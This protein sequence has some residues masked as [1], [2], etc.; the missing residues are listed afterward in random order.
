MRG[1]NPKHVILSEYSEQDP[2][3][4]NKVI[5][6]I[7]D[8]NHWKAHFCFTPK[9]K[10]HSYQLYEYARNHPDER[11]VSVKKAY[12]L[13]DDAGNRIITDEEL[14][15]IKQYFIDMGDVETYYQ[16]YECSF[17]WST[18]WAYYWEQLRIAEEEWR[19]CTVPYE[20]NL[21][22]FSV[23][24]MGMDDSTAIRSFQIFWKELR[25]LEYFHN[26]GKWLDFYANYLKES[27]YKYTTHF[28]PH[29]AEVRELGTWI[30]RREYLAKIWLTNTQVLKKFPIQDGID[31][32]RR[33]LKYCFFNKEKCQ[34]GL[35]ALKYYHKERDDK[36]Q[37]FSDKPKHDWSS[38][39]ADSFRY[40]AIAY[41]NAIR[42]LNNRNVG[43]VFSL[44][45]WAFV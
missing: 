43:A 24:D 19:I 42:G 35:D 37:K 3:A 25:I 39:W 6:P 20:S 21:D 30:S 31:A 38:H 34:D 5:K 16:E 12:E 32:V 26:S 15:D 11:F 2:Y 4:Y 36:T 41:E 40:L 29:D 45:M 14:K 10:N 13:Y 9:W 17:E 18:K 22:T 7:L 8:L 1:T 33:I 44:D 27:P 23:R 28:L